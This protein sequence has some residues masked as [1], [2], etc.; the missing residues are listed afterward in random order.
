MTRQEAVAIDIVVFL[1]KLKLTGDV[2]PANSKKLSDAVGAAAMRYA[3][4]S[5][6]KLANAGIIY[7]KRGPAGGYRIGRENISVGEILDTVAIPR[8]YRTGGPSSAVIQRLDHT[9][10]TITVEQLVSFRS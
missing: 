5:L 8:R 10:R 4:P 6:Q 9:A 3:E 1:A 2:G 7:S